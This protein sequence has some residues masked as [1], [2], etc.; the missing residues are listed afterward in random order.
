MLANCL[1]S[2]IIY[3]GQRLYVPRVPVSPATATPTAT[4]VTITPSPTPTYTPTTP[5]IT[6]LN[7]SVCLGSSRLTN[8]YLSFSVT[9]SATQGIG[10][11]TAFD[12]RSVVVTLTDTGN[13]TYSG[14]LKDAGGYSPGYQLSYYFVAMD[15]LGQSFPSDKYTTTLNGCNSG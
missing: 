14:A 12:D 15:N 10:N 9:L 5:P 4:L 8:L 13:G 2:T 11:V 7:P 6:F 3:R 1:T